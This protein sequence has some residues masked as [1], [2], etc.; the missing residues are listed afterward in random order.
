MDERYQ[1]QSPA[2][3]PPQQ[4][5]PQPAPGYQPEARRPSRVN[6]FVRMLRLLLR[7]MF[8]GLTLLGR[9]LA[10]HKIA[11]AI[12]L[13]LLALVVGLAGFLVWERV[14]PAGPSFAR[15]DSIPPGGDV[16]TYLNAQRKY[17]VDQMWNAF[18]PAHQ[19]TLLDEGKTKSTMRA[20]YQNQK[21]AGLSYLN[22]SYIG[23]VKLSKG[24]A[25]YFY[26]VDVQLPQGR[27]NQKVPFTFL[28]DEDGKITSVSN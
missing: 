12:A 16:E 2:V 20:Q 23:G 4:Y 28:V 19:A 21:L 10:P 1:Q 24:G 13:P 8:Y 3:H 5:A 11:I 22:S 27:G 26:V 6:V 9:A 25:L 17:D 7:R 14:G 18:S 15:A